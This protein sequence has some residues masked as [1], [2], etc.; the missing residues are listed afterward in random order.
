MKK[1]MIPEYRPVSATK[2]ARAVAMGAVAFALLSWFAGRA[3]AHTTRVCWRDEANGTTTFFVATY[4]PGD[5]TIGGLLL[6][7]TRHD[8]TGQRSTLPADHTACQP[9]DCISAPPPIRWQTV[10]VGIMVPG[11]HSFS[12]TCIAHIDCPIDGCYPQSAEFAGCADP[13]GD[14]VCG[15]LDNC[16]DV[17]NPDQ[18]DTD[19]DGIGDVCD[20]CPTGGDTDTDGDGV[21]DSCCGRTD[22]LGGWHYCTE[23]C[24]CIEGE[25][26]CDNNAECEEGLTCVLNVGSDFGWDSDVDVCLAN[27]HPDELGTSTYCRSYCPCE[28]GEG[29]CD[30]DSECL[31]GL[32]CVSNVGANYGFDSSTDVCE[33]TADPDDT[34]IT[35]SSISEA[36][37]DAACMAH[38]AAT[39]SWL[40]DLFR[41]VTTSIGGGA[42]P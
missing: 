11:T 23:E 32:E 9:T 25:G 7:G 40:G 5:I 24:P 19:G 36:A 42:R 20:F 35:S 28:H 38:R 12:T 13:D 14:G 31:P 18:L 16:P 30:S 3:D 29:D 26:D 6:D 34:T 21:I 2:R 37:C 8:F 15:L 33:G 27:C 39:R 10:N 41:R 4:H 1:S 17:S 22:E